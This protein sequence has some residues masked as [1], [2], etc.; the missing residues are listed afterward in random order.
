[1]T[2]ITVVTTGG[3]DLCRHAKEV[4]DKL[5]VDFDLDVEIVDASTPRGILLAAQSGMAFP[6]AVI[7]DGQAFSYGRLSERKLRRALTARR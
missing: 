1:M 4:L 6:P 5:G 7:L 3:C 2:N